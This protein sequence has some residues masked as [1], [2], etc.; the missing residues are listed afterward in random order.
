[1]SQ[2]EYET[3]MEE[4]HYYQSLAEVVELMSVH[5]TKQVLSDLLELSIQQET[6]SSILN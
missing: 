6:I 5:G 2:E 3:T 4:A 1:M